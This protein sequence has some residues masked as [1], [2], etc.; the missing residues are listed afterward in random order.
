MLNPD[1][2]SC[3]FHAAL[4]MLMSSDQGQNNNSNTS[5]EKCKFHFYCVFKSGVRFCAFCAVLVV[6]LD[7]VYSFFFFFSHAKKLDV[8]MNVCVLCRHCVLIG[9]CT[10]CMHRR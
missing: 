8:T 7:S 9:G 6:P 2:L 1:V 3:S 10:N 4:E 5:K